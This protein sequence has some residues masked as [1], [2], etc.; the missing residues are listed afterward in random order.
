M[1]LRKE[2]SQSLSLRSLQTP[3]AIPGYQIEQCLGEGSFGSVWLARESR[4][5]QE[6]RDQVL[7]PRAGC[8]L[9]AAEPRS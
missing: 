2:L 8:R 6:G 4:D 1:W 5:G 7:C 3:G 9:V